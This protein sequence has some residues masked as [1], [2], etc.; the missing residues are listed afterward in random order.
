MQG[1]EWASLISI[2]QE[3]SKLNLS[4]D[5]A[6]KE[7][8]LGLSNIWA[9]PLPCQVVRTLLILPFTITSAN[10]YSLVFF[11]KLITF[12]FSSISS[13]QIALSLGKMACGECLSARMFSATS[14]KSVEAGYENIVGRLHMAQSPKK[15]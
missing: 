4:P 13:S 10:S 12:P 3:T 6:L 15:G 9:L 11:I 2:L 14:L 7:F 8:S 5:V 1:A